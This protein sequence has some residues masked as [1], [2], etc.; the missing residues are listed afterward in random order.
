MGIGNVDDPPINL[1][2]TI[3]DEIRKRQNYEGILLVPDWPTSHFYSKFF[4]DKHKIREPFEV[5]EK[6]SPF[7][8][9]NQEATGPLCGKINFKIFVL[10]FNTYEK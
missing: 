4:E 6:I 1:L 10:H 5:V 2:P 9:Q 3:A 8:Y 7:I